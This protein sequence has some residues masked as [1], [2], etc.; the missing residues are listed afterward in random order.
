MPT[1]VFSRSEVQTRYSPLIVTLHW[2]VALL[3]LLEAFIGVGFLHFLPNTAIKI[4]PLSVHMFLGLA[5]L[6]LTVVR[7]FAR[8]LTPAPPMTS[9]GHPLLDLLGG[10]THFLLYVFTVLAALTGVLLAINSHVLGLMVGGQ[11]SSPMYFAPF[12]HAAVF[13]LFGLLVGLHVI[14]S[15]YHQFV[16]R[17]RIFSR[18][19]YGRD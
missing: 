19:W 17:D 11:V 6:V 5:M 7:I 2:L 1:Q 12:Q 4:T 9:A 8:A 10:I 15:F 3:V 16:R 14:A 13:V 18:I